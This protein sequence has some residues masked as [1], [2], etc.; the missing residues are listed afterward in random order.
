MSESM[1]FDYIFLLSFERPLLLILA[2]QP[3][4][5]IFL[6]RLRI[7]SLTKYSDKNLW[8]WSINISEH[9]FSSRTLLQFIAWILIAMAIAGP[10][11]PFLN[12][13]LSE[14]DESI[15]SDVSIMLITDINGIRES[16]YNSYL[17]Q[18][19]DFVD[20]LNG[21]K[22]GFV[23]LSSSSALISPLTN[24]YAASYFYLKQMFTVLDLNSNSSTN[25][26]YKSLKIAYDAI[27]NSK[28][29]SSVIVY[30]SDYTR[31]NIK[32]S[33]LRKI[34]VLI[35]EIQT[36]NIKVIPIWN[37]SSDYDNGSSDIN[38]VFG[39]I[40]EKYRGQLLKE[41]YDDS[42]DDL[43]SATLFDTSKDHS[44]KQLYAYPLLIGLILLLFSLIAPRILIKDPNEN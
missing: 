3:L 18:L 4:I 28:P 20:K 1:L 9:Y 14:Q 32:E 31:L 16:E 12:K 39:D 7:H 40:S 30:W 2:L 29:T 5:L 11:L 8:P 6:R 15:K 43:K 19:S 17:I 24:D 42:L 26:L 44:H 35:D 27:L 21:E 13:T 10:R 41:L 22:I 38:A 33:Q 23:A 37:E 25:D 34:K 36:H